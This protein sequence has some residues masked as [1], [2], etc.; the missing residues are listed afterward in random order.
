[1]KS[2][3]SLFSAT[4][5][6]LFKKIKR[7]YNSIN[8]HLDDA[9]EPLS[10]LSTLSLSDDGLS[11]VSDISSV[12]SFQFSIHK[13][14]EFRTPQNRKSRIPVFS[15]KK[16]M[17]RIERNNKNDRYVYTPEK[18]ENKIKTEKPKQ[19][20]I[21]KIFCQPEHPQNFLIP[22]VSDYSRACICIFEG[23]DFPRSR[24][25]ERSTYVTVQLHP[26][27]IPIKSPISFNRTKNAIYNGGFDI[28]TSGLDFTSIV[29]L[30][31][32]YD[33]INE[34]ESELLGVAFLELHLARKVDD[35][36]IIVQDEWVDI[37]SV[38][39]KI[40]TGRVR[41]TLIFHN[42][43]DVSDYLRKPNSIESRNVNNSQSE[44]KD[45]YQNEIIEEE[46][47]NEKENKIIKSPLKA[48]PQKQFKSNANSNNKSNSPIKYT[49]NNN[50]L[51]K[52]PNNKVTNN[53]SPKKIH[54]K[55]QINAKSEED[56]AKY[57]SLGIQAEMANTNWCENTE[58]FGALSL[59]T[60]L[61]DM[62]LNVNEDSDSSIPQKNMADVNVNPKRF[63]TP[64][65]ITKKVKH[66]FA[67]ESALDTMKGELFSDS[68][69][70]EDEIEF[71]NNSTKPKYTR[72]SD[73][74]FMK[75]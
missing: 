19:E 3:E 56:T 39:R 63:S 20:I 17:K 64:A 16:P 8:R 50:S 46:S 52:S 12:P 30:L 62:N 34:H 22:N 35:I 23:T 58:S 36:C 60:K 54:S 47:E 74:G 28:N 7:V 43:D 66:V 70:E 15:G 75:K 71:H 6:E 68:E 51:D 40:K 61:M 2:E 9:D 26:D 29:P 41:V 55:E 49:T 37:F 65:N 24:F 32:V 11:N 44:P 4:E 53:K 1:M 21:R 72:Y 5:E 59:T 13:K 14:K 18:H 33:F 25:G 57:E 69:S 45:Y 10:E 48:S 31:S 67:D 73:F 27:I 38:D 42:D